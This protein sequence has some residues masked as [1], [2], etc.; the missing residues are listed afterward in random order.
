MIV[1]GIYIYD[2][3]GI[4]RR[5]E[6]FSDEKISVT[7]SV[8]DIA[9]ISK[10]FTD[11]S[12]SFTVPATPHNN[13]IFKHWYDNDV[14]NG[15]DAR[16]RKNGFIELDTIPFRLGK[17]QLEKAQIKNGELD[18]YQITFF[19]SV[20]TLKDKFNSLNLKDLDYSVL[21]FNYTGSNVRDRVEGLVDSDVK[22]PLISSKNAWNWDTSGTV[23]EDWDISKSAT[24]IYHTDLFPAV[25]LKALFDIIADQIGVTFNEYLADEDNFLKQ[26]KFNRAFLWFKNNNSLEEKFAPKKIDFNTVTSTTGSEGLYDTTKQELD[27]VEPEIPYYVSES[28]LK[29]TFSEPG[30]GDPRTNFRIYTFKDGVKVNEQSYVTETTQMY[31]NLPLSGTGKY[32]FHISADAPVTYTSFYNFKVSIYLLTTPYVTLTATQSTAQTSSNAISLQYFAPDLKLEDFF[33]GVLKAFN[34]TCYSEDGQD[35]IIEQLE[36]WYLNGDVVDLTK[37]TTTDSIEI[38][39]TQIYKSIK[40]KFAESKNIFAVEYLARSKTAYGDLLYDM[41]VDGT[42]YNVELPFETMLMTKFTNTNLQIGLSMDENLAP[43]IPGPVLLYDF[44]TIRAQDFYF[45]NGLSTT[46]LLS[47]NMFGQDTNILGE[48]YTINFGIEQSTYTNRLES[49]SLFANYY[50]DYL[51]NI[52]SKKAR[53]IKIKSI[54]PIGVITNLKLNDRIIIRGKRYI[55][56]SFTTDLTTGDVDFELITDFRDAVGVIPSTKDYSSLDYSPSDYNA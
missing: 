47:Y 15:F 39:K 28:N 4:A 48:N 50:E 51:T 3:D 23:R 14:D 25:R 5:I 42:E 13:A 33:S 55:I 31:I 22:F 36:D 53:L 37:H 49:N 35:F 38:N 45:N 43:I 12:Q 1:V 27:F 17:F 7:S 40:F 30:V 24:P 44:G 9:D 41:E 32:S 56:Q 18:N 52:F 26:P 16:T 6:L 19:G 29:I 46:K 10:T 20:V 21:D 54:L 34:L 8:Q 2:E 11:F